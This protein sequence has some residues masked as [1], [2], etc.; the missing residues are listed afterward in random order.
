MAEPTP[1]LDGRKINAGDLAS[2]ITRK[3]R[4]RYRLRVGSRTYY[5]NRGFQN[6][7]QVDAWI[8][9]MIAKH[10]LDWRVGYQVKLRTMYAPFFIVHNNNGLE[11]TP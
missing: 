11:L 5:E 6:R 3:S 1:T 8:D 9:A 2:T 10:G 4:L 7:R